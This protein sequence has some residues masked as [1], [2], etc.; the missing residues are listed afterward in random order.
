MTNRIY[1]SQEAAE[2]AGRQRLF[3]VFVSFTLGMALGT[4]IMLFFAPK[5]GEQTRKQISEALEEGFERGRT[6]A[7]DALQD[8][9]KDSPDLLEEIRRAIRNIGK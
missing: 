5:E 3:I 2:E 8:V 6:A 4:L 7:E 1:Y 9:E